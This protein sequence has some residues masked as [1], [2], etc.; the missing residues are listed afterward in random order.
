MGH[1]HSSKHILLKIDQLEGVECGRYRDT[2]QLVTLV[3][4][5]RTVKTH[6]MTTPSISQKQNEF[7]REDLLP[8]LKEYN[9][10]RC[11]LLISVPDFYSCVQSATVGG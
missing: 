10:A 3:I 1:I 4:K 5:Q 9:A 8:Q 7:S 2:F 11:C 6:L